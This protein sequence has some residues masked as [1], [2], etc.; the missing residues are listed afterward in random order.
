MIPLADVVAAPPDDLGRNTEAALQSGLYW[1]HVGSVKELLRRFLHRGTNDQQEVSASERH[2]GNA[3]EDELPLVLLTGGAAAVLKPHL[4]S[5]ARYEPHLPLQ[6]LA[7][8][9]GRL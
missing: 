7:L 8:L 6:G 2:L 9:C 4:P 5:L 1:G 3:T